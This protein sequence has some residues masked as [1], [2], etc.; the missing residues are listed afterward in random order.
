MDYEKQ[1]KFNKSSENH[2]VSTYTGGSSCCLMLPRSI[3]KEASELWFA[4]DSSLLSE[5]VE[6]RLQQSE[7]WQIILSSLPFIGIIW[8]SEKFSKVAD[9]I[10]FNY[11]NKND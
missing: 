7:L 4:V 11:Q 3:E 2:S 8:V 1:D 9:M 5:F 6:T 10:Y